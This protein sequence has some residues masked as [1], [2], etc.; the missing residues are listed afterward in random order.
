MPSDDLETGVL[1]LEIKKLV[2]RR[3][4]VKKLMKAKNVS[5]EEMVQVR[6]WRGRRYG[7]AGRRCDV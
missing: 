7:A 3:R 5:P 4:D 6:Q 1:P 2:D